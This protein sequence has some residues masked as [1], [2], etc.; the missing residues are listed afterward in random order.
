MDPHLQA[1]VRSVS[2]L[3]VPS[4]ALVALVAFVTMPLSLGHHPGEAPTTPSLVPRHMT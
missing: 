2:Q 3:V 1:F 4:L